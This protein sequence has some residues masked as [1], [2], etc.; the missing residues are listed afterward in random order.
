MERLGWWPLALAIPTVVA[1]CAGRGLVVD[2]AAGPATILDTEREYDSGLEIGLGLL[3][4]F[5]MSR[6]GV[7]ASEHR[8]QDGSRARQW[9]V[10]CLW[11]EFYPIM[12]DDLTPRQRIAQGP[13]LLLN[14]YP[15]GNIDCIA[16]GWMLAAG[17][18]RK[19]TGRLLLVLDARATP[20]L[21]WDSDRDELRAGVSF[22]AR[23]SLAFPFRRIEIGAIQDSGR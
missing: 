21:G 3:E 4:P 18:E 16:A 22:D 1:G 13:A 7:S 12:E 8:V 17:Y 14:E 2:V 19:L 15:I 11:G 6:V 23:V 5:S 10:H 20:W 9:S